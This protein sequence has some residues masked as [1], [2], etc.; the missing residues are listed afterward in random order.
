MTLFKSPRY[1]SLL[2]LPVAFCVHVLRLPAQPK[3]D[4]G[5]AA[6]P[7]GN[8]KR[9]LAYESSI[10]LPNVRGG[11]DLMDVDI[12]RQ[13]LFVSAEDNHTVEVADLGGR[14]PIRSI[15]NMNE[16]KWVVNRPDE[17]VL[18]V[19]T[20]KDGKVAGL[21]ASTFKTKYTSSEKRAITYGTTR[22]HGNSSSE[23]AKRSDPSESSI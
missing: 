3:S 17:N 1:A 19:A 13:R 2:L 4:P 18:Y 12:E 14:K 7:D 23:W 9:Y 6:V 8:A 20:G 22:R 10:A 11:F 16:P 5:P 15:P 21:D